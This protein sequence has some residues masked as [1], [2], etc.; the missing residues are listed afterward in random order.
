MVVEII[1]AVTL[2]EESSRQVCACL[3]ALKHTNY[4]FVLPR[5]LQ[6]KDQIRQ[7]NLLFQ[8]LT[9]VVSALELIVVQQT[10]QSSLKLK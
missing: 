10:L 3:P 8:G 7:E 2:S 4:I 5:L 1:I 9:A 6:Y